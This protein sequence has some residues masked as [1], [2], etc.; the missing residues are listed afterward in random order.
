MLGA[1]VGYDQLF[2]QM[3]SEPPDGKSRE[4]YVQFFAEC[5]AA[6]YEG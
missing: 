6:R 5:I 3:E 4:A 2:V 1:M